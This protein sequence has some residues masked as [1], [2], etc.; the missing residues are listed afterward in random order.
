MEALPESAGYR[1]AIKNGVIQVFRDENQPMPWFPIDLSEFLND[2]N[3]LFAL[4]A[5]G[6]L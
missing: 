6:P 1:M 5:D 3:I 2:Q 4:M